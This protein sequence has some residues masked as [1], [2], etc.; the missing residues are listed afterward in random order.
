MDHGRRTVL[1]GMLGASALA[2]SSLTKA[3]TPGFDAVLAPDGRSWDGAPTYPDLTS[4]I[5]AAPSDGARPY[6]ILVPSGEWRQRAIVDKP[7][8]HLIGE[9]PDASRIA[10]D[11]WASKPVAPDSPFRRFGAATLIVTAPGFQAHD[12]HIANDW[13]YPSHIPAPSPYD[14]T[15]VSGAQAQALL[16]AHN[17]D[18]AVFRNVKLTGHQDTLW[19]AAGRSYFDR[20]EITGSVDFIYGAGVAVFDQCRIVSR[21]RPGQ[22]FNGFI[23]APSGDLDQPYGLI[24]LACRLEKEPD[25][26][27][28]TVALGRPWKQGAL[29]NGRPMS[30]PR[31]LGQAVYLRCWMDDHIIPQAWYE[32]HALAANGSVYMTQPEEARLFEFESIG[33]GAGDLATRPDRRRQLTATE[34]QAFTLDHV[35][36]TPRPAQDW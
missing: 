27:A 13:P 5:A 30:N 19:T 9:G 2:A 17:S 18:R 6:R 24:F 36:G 34:A 10:F 20:C 14:R 33:P 3:A 28:Q 29:V 25:V 1:G 23:A 11:D 22:E 7:S 31:A 16:L 21:R 8:I 32:M 4:A 12:I 15:G 26:G 35:L